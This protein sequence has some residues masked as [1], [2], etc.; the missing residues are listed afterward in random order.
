MDVNYILIKGN[1]HFKCHSLA[2][3]AIYFSLSVTSNGSVICDGYHD[4]MS[5]SKEWS[6][7]DIITDFIRNRVE[8]V[9]SRALGDD[10]NIRKETKEKVIEAAKR[11]GYRP[12][13]VAINLKYGHTNTV[14]VIVPEMVTPFASRVING[15]QE[16][17]HTK[18][19][20]VIIAESGGDPEK[21]KENLQLM[22]G[23]MV[24]GI[25]ICLCSYKRNKEEYARL[26]QAGMPMVF[27]DRIPY[28]LEV[29]QVIVD[30]YMKSF[31]LVESLIRSGRKQIVHIQGP[32]DIY[33]S[34]ERVRGYKDA[35][36]K[37]G[38]PFDKNNMLIKTGMT[39]E[40]GKKAADIL[41]ER[42]IPFNAI[43]A[44]TET[45][46]I[47][48]MNRLRELGKKIPEE[49]AVASFSGTE[50]SNIVYPKLTTVEPPLYQM[51]KKAA[52]LILEKIKDPASPNHSIVLDAEIKMRASTPRL[53]V[54]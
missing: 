20:K 14:G 42:N 37:F 2:E 16:V 12:N 19:I 31:F 11:L 32:D 53:E 48:A 5:Y 8:K 9:V 35:L 27:Y 30:D 36:A 1:K 21:E 17:L 22:E 41:V 33:N 46:A 6:H 34:I 18:N 28:G 52:E 23:F 45:L 39:F 54:Y 50:L 44:F 49:I 4:T 47:G 7:E 26:Q 13:P 3:M 25:I 38:I 24:D 10:K 40:E 15:I 29:P 43:F 51:G